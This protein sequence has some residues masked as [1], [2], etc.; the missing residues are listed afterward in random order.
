MTLVRW[1]AGSVSLAEF[2]EKV[3][4]TQAYAGLGLATEAC[5][6]VDWDRLAGLAVS[7]LAD[8][9]LVRGGRQSPY[10]GSRALESLRPLL[11]GGAGLRVGRADTLDPELG[12][13]ADAFGHDL[14][15]DAS[16]HLWAAP[17]ADGG[18][19]WRRQPVDVFFAQTAG[20]QAHAFRPSVFAGDHPE[21]DG[22]ILVSHRCVLEAGDWLYV[23]RSW[24]HRSAA[25]EESLSMTIELKRPWRLPVGRRAPTQGDA[26]G[27]TPLAWTSLLEALRVL[28][29][30]G[31]RAGPR[32][33]RLKLLQP[34]TRRSD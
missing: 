28:V 12:A 19:G 20:S 6:L 15:G 10:A 8:V 23:P 21:G 18:L 33:T 2:R 5:Q 11:T 31:P 34:S 7:A 24:W 1:L 4:G 22:R 16:I 30:R 3:L 29:R 27:S 25:V 26:D 9:T 17:P 13:L 14:E 32:K